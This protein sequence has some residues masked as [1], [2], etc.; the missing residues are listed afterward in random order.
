MSFLDTLK[1]IGD[2]FLI[3]IFIFVIFPLLDCF[4]TD[5][6]NKIVKTFW[7]KRLENQRKRNKSC[8]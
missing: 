7:K 4:C 5:L 3:L 1:G 6:R 2:V 8:K